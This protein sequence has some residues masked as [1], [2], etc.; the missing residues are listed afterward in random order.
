M[1]H[2]SKQKK[3]V[4]VIPAYRELKPIERDFLENGLSKTKGFEQ[5]IVAPDHLKID[6]SFGRLQGL[7]T[8]RFPAMYFENIE[9]YNQLMLSA[10]FYTRFADFEYVL[11]HQSDVYLFKDELTDWCNKGFSYIGAPWY[12]PEKLHRG[13]L[14]SWIY[15]NI[16]QPHLVRKR[17]NGWLYNKVGNGGLS[18]RHVD[19]A[20]AVLEQSPTELLNLYLNNVSPHYNEDVFW[21]V[22]AP[23]IN[24]DFL[25]P[26]WKEALA[27]AVEFEPAKALEELNNSLPFG[28][29]APLLTDPSFWERYIPTL[30]ALSKHR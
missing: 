24:Q 17:K 16:W 13:A 27:F 4:V 25:I 22:E 19:D 14:F 12:R 8:E 29:H 6:A 15:K 20:L 23:K 3:C 30:A 18:L 1:E 21:S 26:L 10:D 5:V 28:C 9:G 7:R 2:Q 11:I